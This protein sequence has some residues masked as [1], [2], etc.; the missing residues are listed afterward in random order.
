VTKWSF[1][2]CCFA[3][4]GHG[5]ALDGAALAKTNRIVIG[6]GITLPI[7]RYHPAIVAHVFADLAFIFKEFFFQSVEEKC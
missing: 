5:L 4:D 3:L 7:S 6:I 1:R 2:R